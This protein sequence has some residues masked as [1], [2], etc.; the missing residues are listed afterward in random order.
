MLPARRASL[1]V[2]LTLCFAAHGSLS[3]TASD[4]TDALK[5]RDVARF[6]AC[7]RQVPT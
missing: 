3:S 7:S 2:L 6:A 1:L 4:L 5:A